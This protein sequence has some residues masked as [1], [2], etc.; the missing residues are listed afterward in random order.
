M[1]IGFA[2]SAADAMEAQAP[3]QDAHHAASSLPSFLDVDRLPDLQ[4]AWRNRFDAAPAADAVIPSQP[5]GNAGAASTSAS[6]SARSRAEELSHR[7]AFDGDADPQPTATPPA[8]ASGYVTQ[9]DVPAAP[10]ATAAID[11][12]ATPAGPAAVQHVLSPIDLEPIEEPV[13]SAIAGDADGAD[14]ESDPIARVLDDAAPQSSVAAA[15]VAPAS[16]AATETAPLRRA[17][18]I[19][20]PVRKV[21]P[22]TAQKARVLNKQPDADD[23]GKVAVQ[24][25][26]EKRAAAPAVAA[27][28]APAA[29]SSSPRPSRLDR[30]TISTTAVPTARQHRTAMS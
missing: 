26:G 30:C 19:E 10:A 13:T 1:A 2:V 29:P 18:N 15:P 23:A 27:R 6:T 4:Q 11:Q 9:Q 8:A 3:T 7:F 28:K 20:R 16:P 12:A 22:E 24:K 17:V 5:A 21:L 14:A 25:R